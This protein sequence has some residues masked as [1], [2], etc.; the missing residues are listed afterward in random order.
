[1]EY[2]LTVVTT[3]YNHEKYIEKCIKSIMSQKTNFKYKLLISDDYS[4][5][6]TRKILRKYENKYSDKIEVIY[7]NTNLGAMKN[8]IETLNLVH[9]Q[10]V[11]LC[12]GDDYWTDP[13]KLQK[14]VDF[15]EKNS[16]YTVVFHQTKI[17]I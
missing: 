2:K 4:T 8:F 16:K 12:D 7:R 11:A 13:N 17:I 1:M 15:L 3:T 10:Y 14:Q 6:K 9:S 5:D